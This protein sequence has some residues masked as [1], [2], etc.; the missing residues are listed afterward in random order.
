MT[1]R[2][3][4][5]QKKKLTIKTKILTSLRN[6]PRSGDIFLFHDNI[7]KFIETSSVKRIGS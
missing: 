6:K 1:K 5:I 2:N 7:D 3:E 4:V